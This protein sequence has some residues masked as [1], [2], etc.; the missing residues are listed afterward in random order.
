MAE[1][2][3]LPP[4]HRLPTPDE[5]A[6]DHIAP[7]HLLPEGSSQPPASPDAASSLPPNPPS[8]GQ[9]LAL[10]MLYAEQTRLRGE[11]DDLRKKQ[12]DAGKKDGKG[13][14][15]D[16]KKGGDKEDAD[17]KG[18][19]DK[20]GGDKEGEDDK[21]GGDAKKD[22]E[23]KPPL[24]ERLAQA[25]DKVTAWIRQHPIAF[26]LIVVAFVLL[27]LGAILLVRY[28]DS[29]VDTDDAFVDGHTDP[30]SFRVSGIVNAVYVENTSFVKKGQLLIQLDA[31]DNE[32][33]K[34][35]ASAS[36]AQAQASVRAQA[37]NV[38]IVAVNQR[39]AI[40][41]EDLNVVS[42]R[43]NVAA[44]EE[45]YRSALADLHQAQANQGNAIREEERYRQ[46]V[47][48]EEVTREQYDQRATEAA[49]QTEV[50][51]SRMENASAAS[52]AITQARAQLGQAEAQA[53]Q[54]RQDTPR[55]IQMQREML[56]EQK[57]AELAA[58]AQADQAELNLE[59][60]RIY[61][62]E[63][64]I[65]GDKQVQIATQVAPGQE[66]FALTQTND[67]WITAN[68]KETDIARIHAG[69][70]VTVY[71]DALKMKF[72]GWVEALPGASGAVYSLLPPE[73]ATG[74]YVKVVQRLPVRIRLHLDQNGYQRLRP[75]MSVE[76]KVWLR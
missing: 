37:P 6:Q 15:E 14:G 35:R 38:P 48:K 65:I 23:K 40:S 45:R 64:G 12:E 30:I 17:K 42:G 50:V 57:A 16:D 7:D 32:V 5:P 54:A 19:D 72:Q 61:A 21:E 62:P 13:K 67:I 22:E 47:V 41:R 10:T 39:T 1:T 46:L 60:T 53:A 20:E 68:F 70:S 44:M 51:A 31:R 73:N 43:A 28:L 34:E 49:A 25:R 59:Y 56:T 69:Q 63:D 33:A 2:T 76:P 18:G 75:G 26:I 27:V 3:P 11:L 66:L 36:Y 24:K 9:N 52:R 71:V 4:D 74:N 55:Q 8:T 58:K 29:Y